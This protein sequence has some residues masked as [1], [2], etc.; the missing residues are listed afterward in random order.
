M[1][2]AM[3]MVRYG[4]SSRFKALEA[5]GSRRP[6]NGVRRNGVEHHPAPSRVFGINTFNAQAM[7]E[8]LSAPTYR[9]LQ[10]TIREG[11]KLDRRIAGEVAHAVKE[12]A[13]ERGATHFC[14]WFLP[15][16]GLT[17]EKHYS[18]LAFDTE[19]EPIERFSADQIIQGES[20]A[21][22]FPS[23][24]MRSTFEARGYT[25][26]DPTSPIFIME[27]PSGNTLCIPSIFISYHGHALD[28]KTPLLR[29]METLSRTAVALLRALGDEDVQRVM[30][31]LGVEQ[32]FFLIDRSFYQLRPDLVACGRTLVGNRSAKGQ[33]L[34]DHYFG[35]IRQRILACLQEAE[36]ELHKLGVP[37]TTRHNEVATCQFE[38]APSY[39]QAN[40]ASD[41]N[42]LQME[43]LRAVA[44]RHD[45][46]LLLHEKP[47]E[48]VNGSGKHCNWSL[49]DDRGVNLLAPGRSKEEHRRFL[50]FLLAVVRG[51]Q[52][53]ADLLRAAVASSGNDLRLGANEAPPAI[54]SVFLGEELTRLLERIANG[55]P[56]GSVGQDR[57]IELDLG[58][59]PD[60]VRHSTDR[61][62]TSPFAFT[63]NRFEFRMVASSAAVATPITYLNAAVSESLKDARD[64]IEYLRSQGSSLEQAVSAVIQHLVAETAPVR[65]EGNNYSPDWPRIAA[66]RGLP[67]LARTPEALERLRTD[68]AHDFFKRV[69]IYSPEEL[70][71]RYQVKMQRYVDDSLIEAASLREIAATQVLPAAFRHQ[72]LLAESIEHAD[73]ALD[74]AA[75]AAL[76]PQRSLLSHVAFAIS[77]LQASLRTLDQAIEDVPQ[78]EELGARGAAVAA[79]LLPAMAAVR[80]ACDELERLVDDAV[81]PLPKYREILLLT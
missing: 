30:P 35:A 68:E 49:I 73:R 60:L 52:L 37:V 81:W 11:R 24:G 13:L 38:M 34:S 57:L 25:A 8:K 56:A 43:V 64:E 12:W 29:S 16:T 19:G 59:L 36:Y 27:G 53:R 70:E 26:W 75:E 69:G 41:H 15:Q 58:N 33:Q 40:I 10:E 47:F 3:E 21:S 44:A 17:A 5:V 76:A 65:Y 48:G 39:E 61:N 55:E 72:Q 1:E 46:V 20:D 77:E 2:E 50:L 80:A 54:L 63:G 9:A 78:V 67:I 6:R 31:A 42:Q 51:V 18:F 79:N 71:S 22:S 45:L 7:R 14:H 66:E 28:K 23:G 4:V 74:G 62:R 32:E